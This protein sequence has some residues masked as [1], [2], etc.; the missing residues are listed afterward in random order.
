MSLRTLFVCVS[1][2][3][4]ASMAATVAAAVEHLD[5]YVGKMPAQLLNA[6][7]VGSETMINGLVFSEYIIGDN[8][9]LLLRKGRGATGAVADAMLRP[10]TEPGE[11]FF[12]PNL[13]SLGRRSKLRVFAIA[14]HADGKDRHHARAAWQINLKT[15]RFESANPH[16]VKCFD[17][18]MLAR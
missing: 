10:K 6:R 15:Q 13:C 11:S 5:E 7:A 1:L 3:L 9:V 8:R 14:S 16:D 2:A 17:E 18:A 12:S 4:C